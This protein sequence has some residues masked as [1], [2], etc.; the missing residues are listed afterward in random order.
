[1]S[2]LTDIIAY[3]TMATGVVVLILS[4]NKIITMNEVIEEIKKYSD[5][6]I[7]STLVFT[8]SFF[9]NLTIFPLF[10]GSFLIIKVIILLIN[11]FVSTRNSAP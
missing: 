2:K 9:T 8:I 6:L 11:K 10:I 5:F 7:C 3:S 1:M 4:L